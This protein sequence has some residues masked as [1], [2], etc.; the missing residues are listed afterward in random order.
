MKYIF[1]GA[2]TLLATSLFFSCKKNG[3]DATYKGDTQMIIGGDYWANNSDKDSVVFSFAEFNSNVTEGEVVINM[4]IA[5]NVANVD[6]EVNIVVRE[7]GTTALPAE[8]EL[9]NPLIMP[10]GQVKA[11]FVVK[12]KRTPRLQSA[13]ATLVLEVL[14]NEHFK[15]GVFTP[16]NTII[17]SNLLP[18]VVNF[19][20]TFKIVWTDTYTKPATWDVAGVGVVFYFGKWSPAKH[21]FIVEATGVRNFANLSTAERYRIQSLSYQALRAYNLANPSNPILNQDNVPIQICSN[22]P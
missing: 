21:K 13:L 5:G 8:Y 3:I 22:C 15:P 9:P 14:P 16:V 19:G 1:L 7:Q 12:V 6:R 11:S 2:F 10:A 20:P 17:A 4:N 18:A